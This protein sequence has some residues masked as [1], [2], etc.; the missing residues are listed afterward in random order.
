M[1]GKNWCQITSDYLL[2]L[3]SSNKFIKE[4]SIGAGN[5]ES[6]GDIAW[7]PYQ[8]MECTCE[9]PNPFVPQILTM[10]YGLFISFW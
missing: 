6:A 3:Q 7:F 2:Q 5:Q 10:L 9:N 8:I 1:T 4:F